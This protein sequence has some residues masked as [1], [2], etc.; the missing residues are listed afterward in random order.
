MVNSCTGYLF[1]R[2]TWIQ[3]VRMDPYGTHG[4][5]WCPWID[6]VHMDPYGPHGPIWATLLHMVLMDAYSAHGSIWCT[7]I[8]VYGVYKDHI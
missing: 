3:I 1:L 6:T 5:I 4:S 8:L 7:W 2:L